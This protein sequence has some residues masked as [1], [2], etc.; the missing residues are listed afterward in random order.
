[1]AVI[2]LPSKFSNLILPSIFILPVVRPK[3]MAL[4]C[5]ISR[6]NAA[7]FT[8]NDLFLTKSICNDLFLKIKT[9]LPNILFAA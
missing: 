2:I 1:M 9:S 7:A 4:P 8:G 6:V 5:I 3:F